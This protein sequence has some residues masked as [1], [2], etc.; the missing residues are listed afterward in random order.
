M[1]RFFGTDG[2]RGYVNKAPMTADM[3]LRLGLAAG[4]YFRD[5]GHRHKAIIGKDTRLSGYMLESA[6]T[7]GL[8]A[9]GID[10]YQVG[11]M[12]TPAIA[13]L[14]KNMR[15]DIGVVISASHNPYHD[16]GIKFFD[17]NGYKLPDNVEDNIAQMVLNKDYEWD[18]PKEDKIGRAKRIFDAQGRYI[19]YIKNSFPEH[20]NLNGLRIVI[21]CANGANYKIAPLALEELGAE[22]ITMSNTPN[23]TNINLQCGSLY[24]EYV[25][26]KVKEVRADIGLALDGD[27][28]RLIVVDEAGKIL[29]G[30][31]IMAICAEYLM[32]KGKLKNNT[33]AATS[34]SNM[35][36]EIFMSKKGG[37]LIRTN[38][39]D[40][41]V[42]EAM[43][44]FDLSLGGEKSGHLIFHDY[45][46]TGDGLLAALQILAIMRESDKKL[47]EL[48]QKLELYPQ[49]MENVSITQK[50]D[51]SSV[52]EIQDAIKQ[53]ESE[54]GK[55]GRVV[56]RYSGTENLCRVMVEARDEK[57][58]KRLTKQLA[59]VVRIA[60][61][62]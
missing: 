18:Y 31:Q 15:A 38:V 60:L 30:D 35:A 22:V 62:K 14:T 2:I 33:L 45:S 3:A 6:L 13:F 19:V 25:A 51:L 4:T 27:A 28:D 58:V 49:E 24:P 36:L 53:A 21:D 20:L 61:N 40:R 56:L 5:G 57:Q 34:M 17:K 50:P 9:A 48:A 37:T 8:C 41:Y 32:D 16:N 7:A 12:P 23:G 43:R 39:G 44:Q 10:V 54:L 1:K 46:T 55:Y 26:E 47:S 52:P 42:V 11:P 29:D 59:D